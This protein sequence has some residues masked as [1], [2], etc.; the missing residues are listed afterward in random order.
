MEIDFQGIGSSLL[1]STE[2]EESIRP[3]AKRLHSL[4]R[5]LDLLCHALERIATVR[6][7]CVAVEL[8]GDPPTED[9]IEESHS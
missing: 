6:E 3:I 4:E 9:L 2:L 5:K 7:R 1:Y 8:E